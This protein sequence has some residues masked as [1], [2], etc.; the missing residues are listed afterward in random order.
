M[1]RPCNDLGFHLADQ[2]RNLDEAE[3]LVRDA[4]RSDRIDRQKAGNAE[5]DN[6]AYIDSLGWVLFR[7]GKLPRPGPELRSARAVTRTGAVDPVVWD[8]LG[9][10][11]SGSARRRRRKAAWEKALELYENEP[12][13][14]RGRRDGR[15]DELK[16]KLKLVP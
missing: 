6:A 7:R 1:P 2:G 13:G 15:L 9:D 3:R 10:V 8:H 4:S 16:R 11:C 5:P 12:R 14:T